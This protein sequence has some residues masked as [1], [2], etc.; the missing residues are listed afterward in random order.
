MRPPYDAPYWD[1]LTPRQKVNDLVHKIAQRQ[2][3][4]YPDAYATA[5]GIINAAGKRGEPYAK[6]LERAGLLSEAIKML[7]KYHTGAA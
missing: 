3:V 7:I 2:G 4:P 5:S 6:R 1:A